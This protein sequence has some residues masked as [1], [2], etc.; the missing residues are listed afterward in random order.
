MNNGER[1]VVLGETDRGKALGVLGGE[2]GTLLQDVADAIPKFK[3]QT[4]ETFKA[5]YDYQDGVI[6]IHFFLPERKVTQHYWKELFA[7]ALNALGMEH[8][9]ATK[10]RLVAKYT[11]ELESWWFRAQGYSHIIDVDAYVLRFFEKL[12]ERMAPALQTQSKAP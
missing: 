10:P 1:T 7:E 12:S 3:Q 6:T 11:P 5:E 4:Y 2:D 8:F 9:Q